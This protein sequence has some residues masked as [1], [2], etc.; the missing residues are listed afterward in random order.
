MT[1]GL[2]TSAALTLAYAGVLLASA[3]QAP[4]GGGTSGSSPDPEWR[5]A[6]ARTDTGAVQG[7][8]DAS[9]VHAFK[10]MPYA[11]PP[12]GDNRWRPPAPAQPWQ[13]VRDAT[14]F[15][16]ACPQ[17]LPELLFEHPG[18]TSEDCLTVNV[19]SAASSPGERRPVIVWSHGG[20]YLQGSASQRPYDGAALAARGAVLVSLNHRLG[21]FGFFAHPALSHESGRDASGNQALL[22]VI[23]ALQWVRRN[24]HA[25]GGDA[26]R[27]TLMGESSGAGVVNALLVSPLAAGLFHRAILQSGS[28]LG[29]MQHLRSTWYFLTPGESIGTRVQGALGLAATTAAEALAAMRARSTAEVMAAADPQKPFTL[30]GNRF[31]PIVDGYVLPEEPSAALD[32]GRLARVPVIA[33][34]NEDEGTVFARL[35]GQVTPVSYAQLAGFAYGS[36]A[37]DVLRLFPASSDEEARQAL[38]RSLGTSAF[39]APARRLAGAVSAHGAPAF[40]YHFTRR[41]PGAAGEGLGA[42]HGSEVPYAFGTLLARDVPGVGRLEIEARDRDLSDQVM[43]YWVRFAERGDPNGADLPAWPRFDQERKAA[44]E[45]G[46]AVRAV[47]RLHAE[48]CDVFDA[49][50]AEWRA[51]RQ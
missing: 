38:A 34:A 16:P 25:F 11:A 5:N 20:A 35:F 22:D 42:F 9:G 21:V 29:P 28:V 7:T 3:D 19:W 51:R 47:E 13:G 2:V 1:T 12:T 17:A 26:E 41:R 40:L 46:T 32:A 8:R 30:G 50:W 49:A 48:A 31:A 14:R 36:R 6:V 39:V 37:A 43:R 10:G 45:L 33:G 4:R 18:E 23:A 44:L 24:A 27:V 15:G